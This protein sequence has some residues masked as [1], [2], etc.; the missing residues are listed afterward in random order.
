MKKVSGIEDVDMTAP[1]KLDEPA[2]RD[3]EDVSKAVRQL[4]GVWSE[5]PVGVQDAATFLQLKYL[6]RRAYFYNLMPRADFEA[7][8]QQS[9]DNMS[10]EGFVHQFINYDSPTVTKAYFDAGIALSDVL[11]SEWFN[12]VAM[13]RIA[14]DQTSDVLSTTATAVSAI[15]GFTGTTPE[16][17]GIVGSSLGFGRGV[18]KDTINNYLLQA[19]LGELE[20]AL[21]ISRQGAATL[22]RANGA[23]RDYFQ[24]TTALVRYHDTCTPRGVKAF[25]SGALKAAK[26]EIPTIDTDRFVTAIADVIQE[27]FDPKVTGD[28]VVDLF[29]YFTMNQ[30]EE[31]KEFNALIEALKKRKLVDSNKNLVLK[32]SMTGKTEN[33]KAYLKQSDAAGTLTVASAERRKKLKADGAQTPTQQP[34]STDAPT[35]GAQKTPGV[36]PDSR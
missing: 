17:M 15:L 7:A 32:S 35:D 8:L 16:V 3:T 19:D 21:T 23:D 27:Y 36:L 28:D 5:N 34:T 13:A 29:L 4:R 9:R 24:A 33:L 30:K 22:A 2:S 25:L 26:P 6:A 11:C 10:K 18:T 1:E 12:R 20:R 31:G 14:A